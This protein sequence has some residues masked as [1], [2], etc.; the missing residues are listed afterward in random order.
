MEQDQPTIATNFQNWALQNPEQVAIAIH[1]QTYTYGELYQ[2]AQAIAQTLTSSTSGQSA[3]PWVAICLP[4][5]IEF[6]EC[7]LG[8]VLAGGVAMVLDPKWPTQY[9]QQILDWGCDRHFLDPALSLPKT[10]S[11]TS[12]IDSHSRIFNVHKHDSESGDRPFYVGFT[13]GTT[14][15]PKG[16]IRSHRSWVESFAASQIEFDTCAADQILVPG[17]LVHSLSLYA[18]LEGLNAGATVHIL[19]KFSPKAI[20]D[21]LNTTAITKLVAVP[22][23]LQT[24]VKAATKTY[25]VRTVIAGGSKLEPELR[26]QLPQVFPKADILEY[27]GALELS[28]V[29]LSSSREAVP[30]ESVGRAFRG[31]ELSIQRQ[32]GRG[33]AAIAEVGLVCVKSP[34]LSSGYLES[35][36]ASSNAVPSES[37]NVSSN[38]VPSES[39]NVSPNKSSSEFSSVFPHASSSESSGKFSNVPSDASLSESPS[40]SSN[41]FSNVSS[42]D[43]IEPGLSWSK[44]MDVG[45]ATVGD[46][47]WM[48]AKGYL[49]LVGREA[50][51][52]LTGGMN[53]YPVEVEAALRQLPEVLEVAVFGVPDGERGEAIA[54]AIC[55]GDRPLSR[56]EIHQRLQSRLS[57]AKMP[58]HF[59]TLKDLQDFPRT[60]SGK[61]KRDALRKQ[62]TSR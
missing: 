59:F 54:A 61:I 5:G 34:F 16:V 27:F 7:F 38:A 32:D 3:M 2:A 40:E 20:F 44:V 6:L 26:H 43:G 45:W 35:P 56:L 21:R 15:L 10:Y 13:S 30:P 12:L 17:S 62:W 29:S 31:V 8:T 60:N 46:L 24:L 47:G 19:P 53:A 37:S 1:A 39:S 50:D 48:D 58:R 49:Y 57:A 4:N 41:E 11:R 9:I 14:G 36:N 55:W 25:D 33:E 51:R 22:T 18:V 52:I 28:F 42:G 23:V